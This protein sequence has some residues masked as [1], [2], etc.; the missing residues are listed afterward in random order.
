MRVQNTEQ[1]PKRVGQ[2][3]LAQHLGI[4]QA[5]VCRVLSGSTSVTPDLRDAVLRAAEELGYTTNMLGRNLVRQSSG[6]IGI[7]TSKLTLPFY[8]KLIAGAQQYAD[9][10]GYYTMICSTG[11]RIEREEEVLRLLAGQ[12]VDGLIFIS[13]PENEQNEHI[14]RFH[15]GNPHLVLVNR[16]GVVGG[17]DTVLIDNE[18]GMR[19]AAEHLLDLGH[20]RIGYLNLPDNQVVSD[21][22]LGYRKALAARGL[23]PGPETTLP[24]VPE[25]A[26]IKAAVMAMLDGPQR[27]TAIITISDRLAAGVYHAA[28]ELGLRI[29]DDLAVI[30]WD[31][32]GYG[33]VMI[34]PLSVIVPPWEEAGEAAMELLLR[35]IARP[36]IPP[37]RVILS[38]TLEV[39]DSTVPEKQ[40][41]ATGAQ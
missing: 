21:R 6:T 3:Q 13:P 16:F 29:P 4:S 14:E 30:S 17:I 15:R 2:R 28:R 7:V 37:R 25:N 41:A 20:R 35:R 19:L 26:A 8:G 18:G 5:T 23:A 31:Y 22:L 27:P 10:H 32:T 40:L 36:A 12:M 24:L 38:C 1:R 33:A 34:P 39:A 11:A 9:Q